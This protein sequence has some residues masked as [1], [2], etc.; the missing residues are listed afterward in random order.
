VLELLP[1]FVVKATG[2][3]TRHREPPLL[4]TAVESHPEGGRAVAVWC[5]DTLLNIPEFRVSEAFQDFLSEYDAVREL[6]FS[7]NCTEFTVQKKKTHEKHM[8]Q[9]PKCW[10]INVQIRPWPACHDLN[11]T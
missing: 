9:L 6:N 8:I 7:I 3:H 11:T 10:K 4:I 1:C 5:S 2:R